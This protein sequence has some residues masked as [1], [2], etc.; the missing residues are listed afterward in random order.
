M[1]TFLPQRRVS[2]CF[3][4]PIS[5][6]SLTWYVNRILSTFFSRW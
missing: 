5:V 3:S 1:G 6:N 2:P 4:R